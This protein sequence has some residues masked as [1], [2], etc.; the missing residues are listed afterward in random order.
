MG[1]VVSAFQSCERRLRAFARRL[2][3]S[4]VD[5]DDICQETVMRA[6]EAEQQRTIASPEAFLFGVARNVVRKQLDRQSRSLI[7]FVDGLVPEGHAS[8]DPPLGEGLD[9]RRRLLLFAQAVATLPPQ[10]QRVFVMKRVYGFSQREIAAKLR[11]SESTVEKHVATGLKRCL[12]E[13]E[14]REHE[15]RKAAVLGG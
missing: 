10:C 15:P 5:V 3:A 4:D 9:N 13:I 12:D 7:G 1:S 2:V 6:I 11:I 8:D 14:K